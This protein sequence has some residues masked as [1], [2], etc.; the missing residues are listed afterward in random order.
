MEVEPRDTGQLDRFVLQTLGTVESEA[1]VVDGAAIEQAIG[2][3]NLPCLRASAGALRLA[4]QRSYAFLSRL[5]WRLPSDEV[6]IVTGKSLFTKAIVTG[7]RST[8]TI[9]TRKLAL[10]RRHNDSHRLVVGLSHFGTWQRRVAK[11]DPE[12]AKIGLRVAKTLPQGCQIASDG[13][14]IGAVPCQPCG[15]VGNLGSCR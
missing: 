10:E 4:S 8:V 11:S 7:L 9:V 5:P 13:C 2:R 1:D 6:T 15:L 14:Q 3:W 12:V